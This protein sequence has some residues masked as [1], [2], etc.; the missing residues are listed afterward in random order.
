MKTKRLLALVLFVALLFP[1]GGA[2]AA[3]TTRL[4]MGGS[5]T[6]TWIYL[7]TALL[8]ET[9][10]KNIPALDVTVLATAGTTAN[11]IPMDKGELDLAGASTSG[12]FYAMNGLYFTKTKLANFTSILPATKGFNQAFTYADSPIKTWKDL[13]GKRVCVGARG[14][15]ASIITEEHFKVLGVKPKLVFSTAAEAVEM[16]KDRRVD[17]M[18]Y[19]VGA[20]WSGVMD[21]ATVQ[22]VR[23]LVMTRE[24]QQKISAAHPYQVPDVIPAKTYAFQTED[25]A[26]TMGF[27]TINARPGLPDELVYKLVKTIWEQWPEVVK[28]SPPARWVKPA[29]MLQMVAPI[30]PGAVKYYREVGVQIPDRLVWKKK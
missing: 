4:S 10:K 13:D 3:E 27:Q 14:S 30:H 1:A 12:D 19:G 28:A 23:F 26:T 22:K 9:W 11:Y 7:F 16:M 8:A 15:P 5:S 25:I 17:A 18:V 21:V 6:G 24:E 2:A 20:P 29:D